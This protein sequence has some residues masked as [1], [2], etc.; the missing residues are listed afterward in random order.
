M[1]ENL[2][3]R[4]NLSRVSNR[5]RLGEKRKHYLCAMPP[6]CEI[7]EWSPSNLWCLNRVY[8]VSGGSSTTGRPATWSSSRARRKRP[9]VR[10]PSVRSTSAAPPST[11]RWSLTPTES[12]PSG[13]TG[14]TRSKVIATDRHACLGSCIPFYNYH[15][16]YFPI[17]HRCLRLGFCCTAL[18]CPSTQTLDLVLAAIRCRWL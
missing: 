5:G 14:L 15:P 2:C 9:G 12:S 4:K 3:K 8:S 10:I 6:P 1:R 11:S 16:V 18:H 17:I 7:N 13:K